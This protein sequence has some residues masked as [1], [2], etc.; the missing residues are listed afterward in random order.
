MCSLK[1]EKGWNTIRIGEWTLRETQ[2]GRWKVSGSI[3]GFTLHEVGCTRWRFIFGN[4]QLGTQRR[5][6]FNA[7][8]VEDALHKAS[9]ILF[10]KPAS[11][12][13]DLKL[14]IEEVL[15]RSLS[16]CHGEPYHRATLKKTRRL[17]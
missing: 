9:K 10:P 4:A 2:P 12:V 15:D 13:S 16:T 3:G 1:S 7:V 11:S 14:R 17:L 5:E 8:G 6:A